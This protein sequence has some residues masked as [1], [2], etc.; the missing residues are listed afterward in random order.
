MTT[1]APSLLCTPNPPWTA[2]ASAPSSST[3]T[4]TSPGESRPREL[5]DLP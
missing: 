4:L 3:L 5:V 1:Q 2:R